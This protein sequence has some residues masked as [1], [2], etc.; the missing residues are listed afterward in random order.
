MLIGNGSRR[1]RK[2]EKRR[3]VGRQY[4][5][6]HFG[7]GEYITC[8]EDAQAVPARPGR[9]IPYERNNFYMTSEGPH[10]IQILI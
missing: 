5:A 2:R 1:L 6:Q 4:E 7:G 9:G 10:F 3:K 8:F